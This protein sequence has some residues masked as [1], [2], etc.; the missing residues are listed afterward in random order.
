MDGGRAWGRRA[1]RKAQLDAWKDMTMGRK[2]GDRYT[3]SECGSTIVYE[4]ACPC[5]PESAHAEVCC[6]KPMD[7]VPA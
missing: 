2:V 6:E 5:C 4:K 7:K 1:S 3:C